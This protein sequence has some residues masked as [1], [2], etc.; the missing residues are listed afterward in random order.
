[1]VFNMKS[2]RLKKLES[3]VKDLEQWMALGLVPKKE[4]SRY[5]EEIVQL[6][7]KIEEEKARLQL[8]KENGEIEEYVTP[9]RSPAKTVYPESPSISDI[10]FNDQSETDIDIDTRETIDLDLGDEEREETSEIDV[11]DDED[12]FSDRNRW[13]RGGIMDPDDNAW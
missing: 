7:L 5:E 9:R 1:M 12:P 3:E 2:E 11:Y 8:L 10:D 6:K 4:I 13:R